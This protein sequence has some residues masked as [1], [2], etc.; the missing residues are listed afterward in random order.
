MQKKNEI[1][2]VKNISMNKNIFIKK[3]NIKYFPG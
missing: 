1:Q 3:N 2:N